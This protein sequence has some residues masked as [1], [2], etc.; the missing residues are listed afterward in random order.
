MA[1]KIPT[2][3]HVLNF[4]AN[5]VIG[6][7]PLEEE[8]TIPDWIKRMIREKQLRLLYAAGDF[9][10]E[11]VLEDGTITYQPNT[12]EFQDFDMYVSLPD[13][14]AERGSGI[15][16]D[17]SVMA[18]HDFLVKHY[19]KQKFMVFLDHHD[20]NMRDRFVNLFK[21]SVQYYRSMERRL[22]LF[23]IINPL[24]IKGGIICCYYKDLPGYDCTNDNVCVKIGTVGGKRPVRK[25]KKTRKTKQKNTRKNRRA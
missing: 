8:T 11:V 5:T 21:D 14:Y 6:T 24:I 10:K 1:G 12:E 19:P 4:H 25:S 13:F 22:M 18:N 20:K 2:G 15:S 16:D 17:M 7:R 3:E 23:N 9:V